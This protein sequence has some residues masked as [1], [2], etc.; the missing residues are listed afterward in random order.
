[1]TEL[2]FRKKCSLKPGQLIP[3]NKGLADILGIGKD[4]KTGEERVAIG[5][6][7]DGTVVNE[8]VESVIEKFTNLSQEV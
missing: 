3:T 6:I 4:P 7:A 1:M 2:E 5:F 8:S